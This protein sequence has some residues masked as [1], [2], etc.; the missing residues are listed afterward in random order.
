MKGSGLNSGASKDDYASAS[1]KEG[2][3]VKCIAMS[4][5]LTTAIQRNHTGLS[6]VTVAEVRETHVFLH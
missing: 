5:W 3:A 2:K 4:D 1:F 6:R